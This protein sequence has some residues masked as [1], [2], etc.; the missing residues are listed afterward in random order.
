MCQYNH[1]SVDGLH[2]D[3]RKDK[4]RL[5]FV[6][7]KMLNILGKKEISGIYIS[8]LNKLK[9]DLSSNYS[10]EDLKIYKDLIKNSKNAFEE[11]FISELRLK[12]IESLFCIL[13]NMYE[14]C[15]IEGKLNNGDVDEFLL[16]LQ[17]CHLEYIVVHSN[18]T[19][20]PWSKLPISLRKFECKN[21]I[22][23]LQRYRLYPFNHIRFYD[24]GERFLNFIDNISK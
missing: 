23:Q 4:F 3:F 18:Y 20:N 13:P 2:I 17:K 9:K 19:R 5:F 10:G 15:L 14:Q 1:K 12:S 11:K 8:R 7:C 21:N 16:F 6:E 22:F 24:S